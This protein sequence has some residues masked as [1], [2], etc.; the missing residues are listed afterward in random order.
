M[1]GS[2]LR[3]FDRQLKRIAMPLLVDHGFSPF[4]ERV[5]R[6]SIEHEGTSTIQVIDFQ[7]GMKGNFVGRFTV[8]LGVYNEDLMPDERRLG[9][10]N[11]IVP[12]CMSDLTQR[13]GF[14][15]IAE[16]SLIARFLRRPKPLADDYWWPQSEDENEMT[17]TMQSVTNCLLENGLN[18][19]DSRTS[20]EAF[21]WAIHELDRRKAWK[22][23][24]TQPNAI[25][26]FEASP[27]P[28]Q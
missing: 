7:I 22:Q 25:P 3:Q 24:L 19:L 12:N 13:L 11:P 9:R 26:T 20:K 4:P 21:A 27:F 5:F 1:A 28:H 15:H 10:E 2:R 17:Q 14:F 18:W 8:N 16:Q 23:Q 6:R